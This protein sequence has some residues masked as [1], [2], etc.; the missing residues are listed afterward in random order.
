MSS[1]AD[2]FGASAAFSTAG[3]RRSARAQLYDAATGKVR[4]DQHNRLPVAAI[5]CNPDNPRDHLRNLDDLTQSIIEV[6]VVNAIAVSTV[7]AWIAGRPGRAEELEPD[8]Q[9]VVV[10]GH[11]RL[12]ASRRAGAETIK[13]VVDDG[14]VSTDEAQLEAAFVAN[15]HRDDMSELEEANALAALVQHYGT[16]AKAAQRLGIA[17]STIASK[18]SYLK[19][20]PALQADL[21]EGRRKAEHVRN[22]GRKAPEEQIAE[23][24]A[25]QKAAEQRRRSKPASAPAE[26]SV[27]EQR[28]EAEP[29]KKASEPAVAGARPLSDDEPLS[30]AGEP[31]TV[32]PTEGE[33]DW[34]NGEA[35]MRAALPRLSRAR[36]RHRAL[37]TYVEWRGGPEGMA[38]D[39]ANAL[40]REEC[41][42]LIQALK[43]KL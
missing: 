3:S 41:A 22:L 8:T 9:Y 20:T 14:Y 1:K 25:R 6:G 36:Q 4:P 12:E 13:V 35:F 17:Q 40:D 18:L 32:P 2:L 39:L 29:V 28:P 24:D 10:D 15:Y 16:Q 33:L 19:L 5:S 27:P 38:A 30:T 7:E 34:M 42:A 11:R 31:V 23:A 21:A 26:A 43:S 37:A